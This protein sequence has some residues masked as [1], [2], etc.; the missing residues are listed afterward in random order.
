MTHKPN[1]AVLEISIGEIDRIT[2]YGLRDCMSLAQWELTQPTIHPDD[3]EGCKK[4]VEA[5]AFLLEYFGD[6]K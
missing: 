6:L 5:C 2:C 4:A 3:V 1:R